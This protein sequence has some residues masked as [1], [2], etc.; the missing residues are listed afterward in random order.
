MKKRRWYDA[1]DSWIGRTEEYTLFGLVALILVLT[2]LQVILRK[3]PGN[4]SFKW[5]TMFARTSVLWVG[6]IG[7]AIAVARKKHISVDVLSKFLG[8]RGL[9]VINVINYAAGLLILMVLYHGSLVYTLTKGWDVLLPN[10]FIPERVFTDPVPALFLLMI[11]HQW[12]HWRRDIAPD[13]AWGRW[14]A[15]GVGVVVAAVALVT[16]IVDMAVLEPGAALQGLEAFARR[17]VSNSPMLFSGLFVIMAVLGAPL[18]IVISGIALVGYFGV[19][20]ISVDNFII[21]G[22]GGFRKSAIFIAI[23]L[24]TLAG[25]LMAEG[26]TP[27]R[28]VGLFRRMVGWLPGGVAIVAVIACAFFTAFT[29]A[30]SVTIIALGGLLFPI[31]M[32]EGYPEKFSLGLLTTGGSRGLIFPPAT[33]V[34]LLAMIMGLNG[35]DLPNSGTFGQANVP[36]DQAA[37]VCMVERAAEQIE[38]MGE[39][40]ER[41]EEELAFQRALEAA[42]S[43][44]SKKKKSKSAGPVDEFE[45]GDDDGEF[46]GDDDF[47]D[48]DDDF[49]DEVAEDDGPVDEFELGDDDGEFEDEEDTAVADG[50]PVDEFELGD[51]DGEF[52][53]EE[54]EEDEEDEAVAGGDDPAEGGDEALAVAAAADDD[55]PDPKDKFLLEMPGPTM[56]FTA[57]FVPGMLMLLAIMV[58]SIIVGV[59][60]KVPRTP[61][62]GKGLLEGMWQARGEIPIP[63]IIGFG[64]FGGIIDPVEAAPV[65]AMYILFMQAV[66][67]RDV[68]FRTMI[69]AFV[70]S[71]VLVGG[72]LI[73]LIA[74]QGLLNYLV[75]AKVPDAILAFM[76]NMIP[77]RLELFGMFTVSRQVI[78]LLML[79]VFLLIVGCMMDIFSAILIVMPLILPLGYRFGIYPMHLAVIF[80]TNLEIGYSTPPVGL[81]LFVASLRFEKPVVRL[82]AA[83]LAYL[84]IMLVGLVLI[85]YWPDLSLWIPRLI[86]A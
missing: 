24:F 6:L 67:Y 81:N 38:F 4:L 48:G 26:G 44:D 37:E 71:M 83:S 3:L 1:A 39:A 28:L 82:Y 35:K 11:W 86:G 61:F 68:N 56:I 64:I 5:L 69:R 53:D 79:N 80:L 72:I 58:F 12:V 10:T 19:A 41:R 59:R 13:K 54:G 76:E 7:S 15:Y 43:K 17:M 16:F 34:F 65:T 20:D 23:P 9:T 74:A 36:A 70:D 32:K 57:G 66:I 8:P 2:F 62:S 75:D 77:E 45:L 46:D 25:Y 84:A 31:L 40:D 63:F 85:T 29:G 21:N 52:D 42:R 78:F 47:D 18:Y 55:G 51:D 30:S 33:P 60:R 73:I 14:L 49:D 27:N 50:D 22:Y